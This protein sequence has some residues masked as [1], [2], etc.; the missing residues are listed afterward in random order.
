LGELERSRQDSLSQAGPIIMFEIAMITLD[1]KLIEKQNWNDDPVRT[2]SEV[3]SQ[4]LIAID[5]CEE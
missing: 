4:F 5:S 2:K 1:P 3:L